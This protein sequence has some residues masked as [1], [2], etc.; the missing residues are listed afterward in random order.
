MLLWL[1]LACHDHP[2]PE[3]E[4]CS[5]CVVQEVLAS[6]LHA[7]G[8]GTWGNLEALSPTIYVDAAADEGGDGSREAP[9]TTI[10]D[11]LDAE[12]EAGAGVIAVAAGTYT[13]TLNLGPS[14]DGVVLAGRC[15]ALVILDATD[16][17]GAGA[18]V[19]LNGRTAGM[20]AAVSGFTI[21]GAAG[22]GMKLT[23]GIF[24]IEGLV[25]QDNA[26][27][28]L[29]LEDAG[30]VVDASNLTVVRTVD[31]A[32]GE[33]YGVAVWDGAELKATGLVLEDHEQYGL[34]VSDATLS[35]SDLSISGTVEVEGALGAGLWLQKGADAAVS[36]AQWSNNRPSAILLGSSATLTLTDSD[37]DGLASPDND[38]SYVGVSV[39]DA[40]ASLTRVNITHVQPYGLSAVASELN[41]DQVSITD[42]T[43]STDKPGSGVTLYD[44]SELKGTD[45]AVGRGEFSG[46]YVNQSV[47]TPDRVTLREITVPSGYE[48]AYGVLVEGA[49]SVAMDALMIVAVQG[50]GVV[51][52]EASEATLSD[53]SIQDLP[54]W[55]GGGAIGVELLS[56]SSL[57]ADNC[58]ISYVTGIGLILFEGSSARLDTVTIQRIDAYD[59]ELPGLGVAACVAA[60]PGT[61]PSPCTLE[62]DN[63]LISEAT[64]AGLSLRTTDA[65]LIHST[66]TATRPYADGSYGYGISID[67]DATLTAEDLD[68]SDV[69][70]VGLGVFDGLATLDGATIHQVH[71]PPESQLGVGLTAQEG[72]QILASDVFLEDIEGPGIVS[73]AGGA[74]LV[75][76]GCEVRGAQFAGAMV[77]G[78]A[79]LTLDVGTTV[80][81]TESS[82]GL[83]GGVGILA[84]FGSESAGVP[85]LF[86]DDTTVTGS[87]LAGVYIDGPG[88]FDIRN[89]ILEGG[90]SLDGAE[91]HPWGDAIFATAEAGDVQSIFLSKN[92]LH[93]AAG[94]GLFLNGSTATLED[95][96]WEDNTLD[97]FQQG[98]DE[99]AAPTGEEASDRWERCPTYDRRVE[100]LEYYLY[101]T[102][103]EVEGS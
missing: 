26:A 97:L 18:A 33:P 72:A 65:T 85:G 84:A 63:L 96:L 21:I 78:D 76:T 24:Q 15:A 73:A 44:H 29:L 25:F 42:I 77:V 41:V 66:V 3:A 17:E 101:V 31:G 6:R 55:E 19:V 47:A 37:I 83:G 39:F 102:P 56:E 7:C 49:G 52:R 35:G 32:V 82:A 40:S 54:A 69:Y 91:V 98:C 90:S 100:N 20:S 81:D 61:D 45:L 2:E 93:G 50:I 67:Q 103:L 71:L 1:I 60:D 8:T 14:H 57:V 5:D 43:S 92:T 23:K 48:D 79:S 58:E 38:A 88:D 27:W 36:D 62:A 86:L 68:I 51:V 53:C 16:G 74:A 4:R 46:L 75:C 99:A 70:G 13:E 28:G 34:L 22:G 30:T 12:A 10:S 11:A 95:N 94:A 80:V 87:P 9:F 89:S 64:G 59:D